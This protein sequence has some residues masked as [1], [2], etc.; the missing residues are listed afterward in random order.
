MKPLLIWTLFGLFVA[1]PWVAQAS[2][3]ADALERRQQA[4]RQAPTYLSG[5]P[6]GGHGTKAGAPAAGKGKAAS[7]S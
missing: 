1:A 6:A 7:S 2:D 3:G 5:H 4:S